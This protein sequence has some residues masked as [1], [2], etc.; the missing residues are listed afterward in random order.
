MEKVNIYLYYYLY[1]K[2]TKLIIVG[3]LWIEIVYFIIYNINNL[4]LPI[5]FTLNIISHF[6]L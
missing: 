1:F 3:I 2:E 6:Y 4:E 5:T